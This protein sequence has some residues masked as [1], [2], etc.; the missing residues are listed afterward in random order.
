MPGLVDHRVGPG[1]DAETDPFMSRR[2]FPFVG[3][4]FVARV[5]LHEHPWTSVVAER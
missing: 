5:G 4:W 1:L 3:A 2:A